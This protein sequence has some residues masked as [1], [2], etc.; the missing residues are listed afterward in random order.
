MF[1]I[2]EDR[3]DEVQLHK[4]I[5]IALFNKE[6][7]KSMKKKRTLVIKIKFFNSVNTEDVSDFYELR[8]DIPIP[9]ASNMECIK[10]AE[11]YIKYA[12]EKNK[13]YR[14]TDS[15]ETSAYIETLEHESILG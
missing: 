9:N 8:K 12:K 2:K 3:H 15:T 1:T 5:A 6:H 13:I 4:S 11:A 7:K 14:D 10:I